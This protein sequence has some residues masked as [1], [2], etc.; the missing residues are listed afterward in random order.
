MSK[1]RIITDTACDLP[2]EFL[3]EQR[4]GVVPMTINFADRSYEDGFDLSRNEFYH[5]LTTE[6]KL[7][8]T[9]QPT[10][11]A[12]ARVLKAVTQKGEEA[13]V[14]TISSRLSGTYES[15]MMARE[16]LEHKEQVTV[17]DSRTASVGEGLLV[18]KACAL[19]KAG[20]DRAAIVRELTAIRARLRSVFTLDTLEYLQKGGR[21][22]KVQAVMGEILHV[23]PI[24]EVDPEGRIV[25][26]EK[27]R[28]RRRA[29]KRLLEIMGEEGRDLADQFIAI[30]HSR[31]P[32]EAASLAEEI[33]QLY[34]VK[35]LRIEEI[36]STVGT[37]T[38]PGCLA[39]FFQGE[40]TPSTED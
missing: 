34:G 4:V 9:A 27:A 7:P 32:E 38:G 25:P 12:F 39:V 15:A 30:G 11:G 37:H 6:A 26:R 13:I 33:K 22:G 21:I 2:I 40:A 16:E 14:I 19:A 35:Q 5:L 18:L 8:T 29:V 20:V 3:K 23:K 1:V 36:S 17:F 24:L 28:G 31:C 10:P